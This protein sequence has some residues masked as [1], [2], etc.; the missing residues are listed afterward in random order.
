[1]QTFDELF[2][3]A[4]EAEPSHDARTVIAK[5]PQSPRGFSTAINELADHF[6]GH[7]INRVVNAQEGASVIG[8]PIGARLGALFLN[9]DEFSPENELGMIRIFALVH[10]SNS[11]EKQ[12]MYIGPE[13]KVLIIC[14]SLDESDALTAIVERIAGVGARIEAIGT[15]ATFCDEAY[16]DRLLELGVGEIVSLA[17]V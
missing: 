9:A 7:G 8:S 15:L 1:M 17:K 16:C 10:G 2:H 5:L 11:L 13:D 3:E 14:D 6:V 4:L 12:L